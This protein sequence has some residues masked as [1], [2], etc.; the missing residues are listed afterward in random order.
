MEHKNGEHGAAPD[1]R[2]ET[3]ALLRYMAHHNL[4]HAEELRQTAASLPDAALL[5]E[6]AALMEQA[7][8]IIETAIAGWEE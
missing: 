1:T 3:L 8:K 2:S 5:E 6:A 4:H 7:S